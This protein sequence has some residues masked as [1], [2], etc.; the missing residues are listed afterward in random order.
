[1]SYYRDLRQ[2]I[3]TLERH[4]KLFRIKREILRETELHPMVRW[5]FR[6]LGESER[7]AFLFENVTS[8][9]GCK[10]KMPVLVGAC[11]SSTSIYALGMNCKEDEI[12]SRWLN[13]Q[14]EPIAPVL[15]PSGPVQ[16]VEIT[17]NVEEAVDNIP[18]PL[19]GPGFDS[20]V[21][22]TAALWVTADPETGQRNVGIYSGYMQKGGRIGV[23]L[24]AGKDSRLHL[25]KCREQG[26]PLKVAAVIGPTPNLIYAAAATLPY[27]TDEYAIAGG[28]AGEP[29]QVVRCKTSDLLVPAHA[30]MI[31]EGEIL[32]GDTIQGWPFGEYSGYMAGKSRYP[33]FKVNHITH[34]RT[35]ILLDLL[36]EHAPSE[37]SKQKQIATEATFFHFLKENVGLS[38]VKQVAIHEESGGWG[39]FVIQ[40]KVPQPTHAWQALYAAAGLTPGLGKFFVVV[41]DDIDPRDLDAV[42]WALVFRAQPHRDIIVLPGKRPMLDPSAVSPADP[43]WHH[44]FPVPNGASSLLIN[45]VRK[46]PYPPVSLPAKEFMERARLIWEEEKLPQLKPKVPWHGYELGHWPDEFK[47]AAAA[48]V[49]GR[50]PEEVKKDE[51]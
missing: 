40:M 32:P 14:R 33:R 7:R 39:F 35:P 49:S 11:A 44:A 3:E 30:E 36:A 47:K 27:G 12:L 48:M 20:S 1:M 46:W 2:Y 8:V 15:V 9:T 17:H 21:R 28:I 37:G 43:G 42:I 31:L 26:I 4:E 38:G 22:L 6:G 51:K 5:Q 16:E 41:D 25:D 45:A 24:G 23:G 34:R 18:V 50:E 19:S 13:A 10:Y 29:L